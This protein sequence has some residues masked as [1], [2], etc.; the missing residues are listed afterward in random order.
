MTHV[1][2][3]T[4]C[5]MLGD[6]FQVSFQG[7]GIF[8]TCFII[9][10]HLEESKTSRHY[11]YTDLIIAHKHVFVFNNYDRSCTFHSLTRSAHVRTLLLML[12]NCRIYLLF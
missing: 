2:Y 8:F 10:Y 6:L 9:Y 1:A 4:Q 5:I 3:N 7:L 11:V 12:V